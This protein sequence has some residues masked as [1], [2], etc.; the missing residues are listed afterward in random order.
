ML[1]RLTIWGIVFIIL[2][3]LSQIFLPMAVSGGIAKAIKV[4]AD[5]E[6]VQVQAEKFPAFF[7]LGGNFD[8]ITVQAKGAQTDK[9]IFDNLEIQLEDV[10]I[11]ALSLFNKNEFLMKK[12]R[13]ADL[14]AIVSEKEL[15]SL[16]NR[17]IKGA[18]NAE[19]IITPE[20]VIVKSTLSLGNVVNAEVMLEGKI[21]VSDNRIVFTTERFDIDN[22][23]F[24]KFGG[25]VFTDLVLAD[26]KQLPFEVKIK[27]IE[28]GN[29]QVLIFADN[30]D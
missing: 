29:K 24:G 4:F 14:K 12:V 10:Q 11:D 23:T 27:K 19:V 18:K 3:G 16:I 20:K 15:A 30:H 13:N 6:Q 2:I 28:L 5:T 26:F 17:K 9:I 7:M 1:K 21:I 22:S 8:K 25:S